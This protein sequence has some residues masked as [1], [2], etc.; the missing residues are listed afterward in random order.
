MRLLFTSFKK[1]YIEIAYLLLF[2]KVCQRLYRYD[3]FSI[4][5]TSYAVCLCLNKIYCTAWL[6]ATVTRTSHFSLYEEAGRNLD[7]GDKIVHR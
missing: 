1:K 2:L 5:P 4:N 3:K 6:T 7:S